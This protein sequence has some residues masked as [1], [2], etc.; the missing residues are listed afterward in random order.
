LKKKFT[1]NNTNQHEQVREVKISENYLKRAVLIYLFIFCFPLCVQAQ[2]YEAQPALV[3]IIETAPEII[4][5]SAI[6]I[7]ADTGTVL[8]SKN[9]DDEIPPASLQN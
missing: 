5:K 6:L 9:P 3:P 8:Y 2:I 1:T 4:S 7:D